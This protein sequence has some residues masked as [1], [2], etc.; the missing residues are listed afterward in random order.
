LT[1]IGGTSGGSYTWLTTTNLLTPVINWTTST[2][3]VFDGSG[4]FSNAIPINFSK[5]VGF[6]RLRTP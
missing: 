3:G 2:T 4:N 6:F 5:P 1:G